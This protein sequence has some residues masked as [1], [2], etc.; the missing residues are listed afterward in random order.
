LSDESVDVV[1]ANEPL[2]YREAL[3]AT[4][5]EIRPN[6]G[7]VVV[8]PNELDHAATLHEPRVVVCSELTGAIEGRS[9]ALLYPHG[10]SWSELSLAGERTRLPHVDFA[11]L[12][13]F[14]DRAVIPG[15]A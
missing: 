8:A 2:A 15:G 13:A 9:W 6:V 7:T 4:L 11:Q 12:L 5:R 1:V 10:A 14:I 3:A